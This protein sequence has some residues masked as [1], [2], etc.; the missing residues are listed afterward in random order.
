M[1]INQVIWFFFILMALQPIVKQRLL[2]AS[3]QRLIGHIERQRRSRVIL[4]V[5][6]QETM[7]LVGFPI[8]RY[9][10]INDAEDVMRACEMTDPEVPL[11]IV[12][13]TPGG[14]VLAALQIARAVRNHKGKVTVFVPHYAMS[15]GTLIALGADE[16]VLSPHAVLGPVDPQLGEHP[17]ASLLKVIAKKPIAEIDDQTLILAD[18]AEK[19]IAQLRETVK[20]LLTRSQSADQAERLAGLLAT[21][22]WTHDYPITFAEAERLGLKVRS[23]M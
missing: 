15:G 6:R 19:A 16:I 1:D 10:D 3:R 4:L 7:S 9:I 23:G 22:T 17:A 14:L 11:D 18:V 2:E 13:H 20:E 5:H 8:M 21:G 12:L